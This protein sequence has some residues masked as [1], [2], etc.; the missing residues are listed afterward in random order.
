MVSSGFY[1][2]LIEVPALVP[3]LRLLLS[4]W[5]MRTSCGFYVSRLFFFFWGFF[6]FF[7]QHSATLDNGGRLLSKCHGLSK[8]SE[9]LRALSVIYLS[10]NYMVNVIQLLNV[11]LFI[12]PQNSNLVKLKRAHHGNLKLWHFPQIGFCMNISG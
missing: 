10:P 7:V 6:F 5:T 11:W 8:E 4:P 3:L 2:S 9:V 12:N 1:V